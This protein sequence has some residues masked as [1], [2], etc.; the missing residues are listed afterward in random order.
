[1][2]KRVITLGTWDGKPIEWLVLKEEGFATLVFAKNVIQRDV[3]FNDNNSNKNWATSDI[4]RYLN[5]TFYEV[6]FSAEE[7]KK[8]INCCLEDSGFS[9]DNIFLLSVN[10]IGTYANEADRKASC[11]YWLRTP[12]PY[13]SNTVAYVWGEDGRINDNYV[14]GCYA[15]SG[16]SGDCGV[17]PAM[18]IKEQE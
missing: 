8:I 5:R 4:R 17:R 15:E 11:W 2:S 18:W 10:E 3:K 12:S 13:R 7:K 14:D 6:S 9:K 16:C 1:M